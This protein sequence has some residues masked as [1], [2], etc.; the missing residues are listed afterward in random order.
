MLRAGTWRWMRPAAQWLVVGLAHFAI[1]A[2]VLQVSPQ[3]RRALGEVIQASLIVP[4]PKPIA[5][6]AEPPRRPEARRPEAPPPPSPVLAAAPRAG[7]PMSSF[8]VPEPPAEPLPAALD[9]PAAVVAS[10]PPVIPPDFTADYLDNPPPQYPP[11]SRRLGETGRVLLRVFVSADG[12]AE[13]I[14]IK[15]SSGFER[16][17]LAAREAV[18]G[19]RF[20]P[21]RRGEEPINA[22]VQVPILFEM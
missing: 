3:A 6:S 20:V 10:P 9:P 4:S 7:Q 18:V 14:E 1:L 8:I 17:D 12:R 5:S 22:W 15:D 21:A 13:R 11:M 2:I 19:W 16:L